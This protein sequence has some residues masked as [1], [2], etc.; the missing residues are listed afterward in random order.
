MN[1]GLRAGL[2]RVWP[3]GDFVSET[4]AGS[5]SGAKR[6]RAPTTLM[7]I[8]RMRAMLTRRLEMLEK[9]PMDAADKEMTLLGTMSRT[10]G[11]A[12]RAR[13]GTPRRD[14]CEE[15]H[16]EP[17]A[18]SAAH[19]DRGAYRSTQRALTPRSSRG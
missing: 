13:S 3:V 14:G 8:R 17:R 19:E 16:G 5:E 9:E 6:A 18:G 2:R 15:E 11:E 7:L 10:L 1:V 4:D 12:H